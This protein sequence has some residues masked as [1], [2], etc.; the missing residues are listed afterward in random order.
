MAAASAGVSQGVEADRDHLEFFPGAER[1]SLETLRQPV[2]HLIAEHRAFVVNGGE[3]HRAAPEIF[4]DANLPPA[5]VTK[6]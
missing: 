1:D 3:D 2:E 6:N 4:T 5:L